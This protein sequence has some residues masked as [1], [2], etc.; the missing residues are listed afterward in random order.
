MEPDSVLQ[1]FSWL[2]VALDEAHT[3]LW[4]AMQEETPQYPNRFVEWMHMLGSLQ[5]GQRVQHA[6]R[7]KDLQGALPQVLLPRQDKELFLTASYALIPF[8]IL[9]GQAKLFFSTAHI[10]AHAL[11]PDSE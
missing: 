1:L 9:I 3:A 2:E 8:L 11:F 10:G 7:A 4:A 6:R 5:Y